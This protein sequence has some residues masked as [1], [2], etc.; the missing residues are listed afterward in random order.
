MSASAWEALAEVLWESLAGTGRH[1]QALPALACFLMFFSENSARQS[2]AWQRHPQKQ[3]LFEQAGWA[4]CIASWKEN[5]ID[6][7]WHQEWLH[8]RY[9]G[10]SRALSPVERS[11]QIISL[12][13]VEKIF[14]PLMRKYFASG[15]EIRRRGFWICNLGGYKFDFLNRGKRIFVGL[16]LQQGKEQIKNSFVV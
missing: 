16:L 5:A 8:P 12:S 14:Y 10:H 7:M 15:V 13:P 3:M 11:E 6:S 9:L 1:W 2:L 4:F